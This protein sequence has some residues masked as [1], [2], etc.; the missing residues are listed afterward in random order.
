MNKKELTTVFTHVDVND[1]ATLKVDVMGTSVPV[2]MLS[3]TEES[4]TFKVSGEDMP[5]NKEPEQQ[6]PPRR[7]RR[8]LPEE[9]MEQ[10]RDKEVEMLREGLA[11]TKQEYAELQEENRAYHDLNSTLDKEIED[12]KQALEASETECRELREKV[13]ALRQEAKQ[14]AIEICNW[15]SI[16]DAEFNS[17]EEFIHA[18]YEQFAGDNED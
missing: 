14:K 18:L 17:D 3:I 9:E 7:R 16:H 1:D 5:V 10:N 11:K 8:E 15:I 6:F 4:V 12:C 2:T 13:E